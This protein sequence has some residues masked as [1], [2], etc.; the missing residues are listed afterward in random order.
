MQ[1]VFGLAV[2]VDLVEEVAAELEASATVAVAAVAA[3]AVVAVVAAA[4]AAVAAVAV[5]HFFSSHLLE[6]ELELVL[7]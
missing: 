4:V 6:P 5:E 1:V 7:V 3:V 2:A